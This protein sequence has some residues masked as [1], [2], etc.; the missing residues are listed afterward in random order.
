MILRYNPVK[1]RPNGSASC[2]FWAAP[3]L[4]A[5]ESK[6]KRICNELIF[7]VRKH[8]GNPIM[9]RISIATRPPRVQL[10]T[11]LCL[12]FLFCL[13]AWFLNP[14]GT[15]ADAQDNHQDDQWLLPLP[16]VDAD[17]SI[18]TCEQVLRYRWGD[19]ISSHYQV[20]T[21]LK[22][23]AK[24]AP[25]R[26]RLVEYGRSYEGRSL[27]YLVISSEENIARLDE[28]QAANIQLSDPRTCLADEAKSLIENSPAIVWLAYCVHGNEIS[29]SDAA[30]VTA[31]HLL[32]D[33]RESNAAILKEL[34]LC[35]TLISGSR[36]IGGC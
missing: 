32:A 10:T 5:P 33:K 24:A 22:A 11:R 30:L 8:H 4:D 3:N 20:E 28:I 23:L 17:A 1:A 29:P 26:T 36:W 15:T 34:V 27:N 12:S 7:R 21:Y 31:Y 19:D 18:P 16:D 2:F 35:P 14:L 13:T 9:R 25:K 6:S